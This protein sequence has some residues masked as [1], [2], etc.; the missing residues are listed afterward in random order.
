M[1]D[2]APRALRP[3]PSR[4]RKGDGGVWSVPSA[5]RRGPGGEVRP[6]PRVLRQPALNRRRFVG[7]IVVQHEM[8]REVGGN[9]RVEAIQEGLEL[10][11]PMPRPQA[12]HH[13]PGRSVQGGKQAGRPVALAI[14]APVGLRPRQQR[15]HGLLPVHAWVWVFSSTQNT[16]ACSGGRGR[17]PPHRG[18]RP[19]TRV[20]RPLNDSVRWGWRPKARQMQ[21][22]AAWDVCG[23]R[24]GTLQRGPDDLLPLVIGDPARGPDRGRSTNPW[25]PSRRTRCRPWPTV[26]RPMATSSATV[27]LATPSA[28]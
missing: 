26:D 8:D 3:R 6:K 10:L 27:R 18:P 12:P 22:T 1:C 9:R 25:R 2:M 15:E 19:Q 23:V 4:G 17:W 14:V 7:R 20:G 13:V 16:T 21:L 24:W 28:R 11:G 5:R